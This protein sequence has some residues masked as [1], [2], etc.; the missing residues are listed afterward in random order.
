MKDFIQLLVSFVCIALTAFTSNYVPAHM[1]LTFGW[2]TAIICIWLIHLAGKVYQKLSKSEGSSH[3]HA[4]KPSGVIDQV[5]PSGVIEIDNTEH[6]EFLRKKLEVGRT[7]PNTVSFTP[8]DSQRPA[9]P[10]PTNPAYGAPAPD[11]K[12]PMPPL[13][14]NT[15]RPPLRCRKGDK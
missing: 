5:N 13:Q 10:L 4:F 3:D 12:I 9:P 7:A 11:Y 14:S 2:F 15:M 1:Q 8:S 6:T